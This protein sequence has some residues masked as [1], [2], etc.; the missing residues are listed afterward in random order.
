MLVR[1]SDPQPEQKLLPLMHIITT[2][3]NITGCGTDGTTAQGMTW[4]PA[5]GMSEPCHATCDDYDCE[6][7]S[8][9]ASV[10]QPLEDDEVSPDAAEEAWM[11]LGGDADCL[12]PNM[13]AGFSMQHQ[14]ALLHA[15]LQAQRQEH[16][17][18]MHMMET[19][20]QNLGVASA[21]PQHVVWCESRI[22]PGL[23]YEEFYRGQHE[24][25]PLQPGVVHRTGCTEIELME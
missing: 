17:Q 16:L 9:L 5:D 21:D 1:P 11:L 10:G 4:P 2:E 12:Q 24:L 20:M 3:L 19:Y 18:Q 25:Q 22:D 7:V 13:H 14:E 8:E 23:A 15:E 6:S